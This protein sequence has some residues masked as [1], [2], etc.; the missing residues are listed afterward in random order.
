M[1]IAYFGPWYGEFGWEL[2]TWQAYC[3]YKSRNYD[4][5]YVCSFPDMAPLYEDFAE[6]I[7]HNMQKRALDWRSLEGI[8]YDIP[9]DATVHI[10]PHKK[11]KVEEQEFIKFG[12]NPISEFDWLIHPR[13][14]SKG[15]NKNYPKPLWDLLVK[16]LPGI[17]ATIGTKED[18][19]IE[20]T[21]DL[22][23]ISL[24]DLMNYIAGSSVV[25]GQSSGVM[26]L[27]TLCNTAIVVWGDN[28]TYFSETLETRYKNTWNPFK[29]KVEYIGE[30]F[31]RPAP[32]IIVE[33]VTNILSTLDR[34]IDVQV[35]DDEDENVLKEV[36]INQIE[37]PELIIPIRDLDKPII[38]IPNLPND[39]EKQVIDIKVVDKQIPKPVKP[40][41]ATEEV[42]L[43]VTTEMAKMLKNAVSTNKWFLTVSYL[44]QQGES[45]KLWH[46]WELRGLPSDNIIPSLE[47]LK[48]DVAEKE[49]NQKKLV[50]TGNWQ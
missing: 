3:R 10:P 18:L 6:F 29:S 30:D 14:T 47:H 7:P 49:L 33:N 13:N 5:V 48:L 27:A 36:Y 39:V 16:Q 44:G 15:N 38:K 50:K 1:K 43:T 12:K 26:H 24:T 42:T 17:G 37:E 35:L 9:K 41:P 21:K 2:L 46:C 34:T 20:G 11:Y 19:Y 25:I 31:W 32:E 4:K 40:I 28:K 8:Q 22:R 45:S 23:G